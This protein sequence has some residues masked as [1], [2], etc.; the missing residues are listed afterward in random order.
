[1]GDYKMSL[2]LSNKTTNMGN[3]LSF[4][5]QAR[6]LE[7]KLSTL[8]YEMSKHQSEIHNVKF[9]LEKSGIHCDNHLEELPHSINPEIEKLKQNLR[10]FFVMQE[11]ENSSQS[12]QINELKKDKTSIAGEINKSAQDLNELAD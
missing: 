10:V 6:L 3:N 7:E 11:D 2:E 12:N 8:K 5:E 9:N 1:M 4:K